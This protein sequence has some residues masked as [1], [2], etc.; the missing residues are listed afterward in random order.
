MPDKQ[1]P[2]DWM[3][4]FDKL[5]KSRDN[6]LKEPVDPEALEALNE[7]LA[8]RKWISPMPNPERK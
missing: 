5:T 1:P 4:D 8:A 6:A 2:S 7:Q 3:G